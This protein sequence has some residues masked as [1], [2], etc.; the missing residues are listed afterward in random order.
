MIYFLPIEPFEARYTQQWFDWFSSAFNKMNVK[1]KTINPDQLTDK[2]EIGQVL[3]CVNTNYYKSLQIAELMKYF[4][5]NEIKDGDVIFFL[6]AWFPGIEAL[7]YVRRLTGIK[8]KMAGILHAGTWDPA[9]FVNRYNFKEG[10]FNLAEKTWLH[11]LDEIYVASQF[12]YMLITAGHND[13]PELW[14]KMKV[15][16]FP[17]NLEP[18]PLSYKKDLKGNR[19]VFSHRL[20]PEKDPD[21]FRSL[22]EMYQHDKSYLNKDYKLEKIKFLITKEESANKE[23]YYDILSNAKVAISFSKQET[24]GISMLESCVH[25]CLP[26]VPDRLSYREMYPEIFQYDYNAFIKNKVVGCRQLIKKIEFMLENYD[27]LANLLPGIYTKYKTGCE[28]IIGHLIAL[29]HKEDFIIPKIDNEQSV[30]Q[31]IKN[32]IEQI[33]LDHGVVS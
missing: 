24:F 16:N 25:G 32:K 5:K 11:A 6:D 15:V 20:D 2:I 19:V 26:L 18:T 3:D 29:P 21:S 9:D 1:H 17:L 27:Q 4:H 30:D 31:N 10:L 7:E 13:M 33:R 12:H 22:K 8:F 23:Q 14:N 28:H